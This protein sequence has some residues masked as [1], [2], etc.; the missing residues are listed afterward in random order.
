M[1]AIVEAIRIWR[2]YL[3]GHKF[4]IQTDQR[5]LKYFLD[6]HVATPEQQKWVTKLMRYDYEIICRENFAADALSHKQGSPCFTIFSLR[7]LPYGKKS[8]KLQ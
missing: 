8:E 7:K 3:L 1:L 2:P 4:F 5:S 6:Q